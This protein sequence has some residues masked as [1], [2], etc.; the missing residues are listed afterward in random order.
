[1][2]SA[3]PLNHQAPPSALRLAPPLAEPLADTRRRSPAEEAR[4]LVASSTLGT[5]ST[6]SEDGHPWGSVVSYA[7]IGEGVPVLMLSTL[8][9]HGRNL[10]LDQRVSL[11]VSESANGRDPLDSG[12][13]TLAG[14][15]ERARDAEEEAAAR[16]AYVEAVPA[17][18]V[19]GSFGDFSLWLLRVERVRWV[20]GFGRM[21]SC[22]AAAYAAVEPDPVAPATEYAVTHLNEDHADVLLL[23]AQRLAGYTD[24]T[25]ARCDR[26]DRYGLDLRIGTPR[27][28]AAARVAFTEPIVAPDGLRAAS[29]ELAQRARQT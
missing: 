20:G 4:T 22:D 5:L 13:V 18:S 21:D 1:M 10:A 17:A 2:S 15:A 23:M 9:E 14:R 24:A 28:P 27:G 26:A 6:L 16:A 8:A 11:V 25:T 29:V 3:P 7:T 19:F 12:R